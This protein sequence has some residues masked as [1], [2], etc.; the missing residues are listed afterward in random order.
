MDER[1]HQFTLHIYYDTIK[2]TAVILSSTNQD[3]SEI[4]LGR[5]WAEKQWSGRGQGWGV[6]QGL[7]GVAGVK[8]SGRGW[9]RL[10][11]TAW[12]QLNYERT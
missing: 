4:R 9:S 12:G 6:R 8:R 3:R 10:I 11:S 1:D 2:M 7:A 5:S